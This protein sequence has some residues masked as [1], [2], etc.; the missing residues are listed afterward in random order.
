[1]ARGHF[2][3]IILDL[4]VR[5]EWILPHISHPFDT[6]R[7]ANLRLYLIGLSVAFKMD[8]LENSTYWLCSSAHMLIFE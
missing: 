8:R 6:T 3:L 7:T 4:K 2:Y 5:E 1:M